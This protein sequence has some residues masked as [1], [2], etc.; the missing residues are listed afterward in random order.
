MAKTTKRKKRSETQILKAKLWR[1]FSL[2]VR[3]RDG[4]KCIS[5]GQT[6]DNVHAGHF[7]H[8]GSTKLFFD[9][10][11]DER[12]VNVQCP[13]CNTFQ[14]GNLARYYRGIE[15]KWGKGTADKL[16]EAGEK[17]SLGHKPTIEEL[18]ELIE[19]YKL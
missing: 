6:K 1:V 14:H 5:C 7:V 8:L 9:R 11:L 3:N 2:Y 12:N 17:R 19:Y 13:F 10:W 18:K 15:K 16:L 4:N